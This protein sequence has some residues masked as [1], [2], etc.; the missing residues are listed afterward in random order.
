MS[1]IGNFIGKLFGSSVSEPLKV[2]SD[3]IQ[4]MTLTEA[5]KAKANHALA[6]L[7]AKSSPIN[8]SKA[9]LIFICDICMALYWIPQIIMADY[10]WIKASFIAGKLTPCKFDPTEIITL[11]VSAL[12]LTLIHYKR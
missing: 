12:G 5:Q 9:F 2:V 8:K 7:N 11:L 3:L 1:F 4:S 6:L 10:F